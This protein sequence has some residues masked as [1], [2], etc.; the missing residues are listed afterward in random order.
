MHDDPYDWDERVDAW[1]E[2]ASSA[3]FLELRDRICERAAPTPDDRVVDLGAGTGLLTLALAPRVAEVTALDISPRMLERLDEHAAADGIDNVR[4]VVGD[5]RELPLEDESAT[6]VVSSYAFHHLEDADKELALTEVR[7][8]LAPDGRLVLC[9]MMF[10]LSLDAR[11]RALL[12]DKLVAIA[13]RG[14]AGLL[15]IARNAGRVAAGRW[16]HPSPPESWEA[17]LRRRRFEEVEVELLANEA[18]LASAVRPYAA[19]PPKTARSDSSAS[20]ARR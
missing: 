14:P 3:A 16:E 5:L 7:R 8:V 19:T 18:G 2:V 15:R 4:C 11:D 20:G 13:R 1:E 12:R 6:L 10:S 17:M 9:D